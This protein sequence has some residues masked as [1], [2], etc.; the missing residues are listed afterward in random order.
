MNRIA[1]LRSERGKIANVK[2]T[3]IAVLGNSDCPNESHCGVVVRKRKNSERKDDSQ[4]D[5]VVRKR[6]CPKGR[7]R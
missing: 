1:V 6:E 4:C 7:S 5:V 3:L 2:T